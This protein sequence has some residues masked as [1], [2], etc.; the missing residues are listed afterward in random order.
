[1][2]INRLNLEYDVEYKL[3]CGVIITINHIKVKDWLSLENCLELLKIYKNE[4]NDINVIMMSYLEYLESICSDE[5]INSM[6]GFLISS[7]IKEAN[8][9]Y[10]AWYKKNE[11]TNYVV[12]EKDKSILFYICDKDF[13]DIKNIILHQNFYNYNDIYINPE[14][15]KAIDKQRSLEMKGCTSPTLEKQKIFVMGKVGFSMSTIN[16]MTYREFS[17]LY[18]QQVDEDM[19]FARNIL[20]SGYSFTMKED[21]NH[22]LYEKEKGVLDDILV[23]AQEFKGKVNQ[24]NGN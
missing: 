17:Q 11:K 4:I 20:K 15:R 6:F 5:T 18:K 3:K 2:D 22:P 23:D 7:T 8:N 14:I 1:M 12:T 24:V 19:Y 21:I 9:K 10:G 13:K 16:N